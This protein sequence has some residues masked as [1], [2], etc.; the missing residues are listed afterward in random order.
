MPTVKKS[1][2]VIKSNKKFTYYYNL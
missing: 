2:L 1:E